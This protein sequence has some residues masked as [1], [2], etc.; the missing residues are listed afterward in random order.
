MALFYFNV[1]DGAVPS[2]D[3]VGVELADLAA[4]RK[5]AAVFAGEML[6]D[7]P[8]QF[9]DAQGWRLAVTDAMGRTLFTIEVGKEASGPLRLKLH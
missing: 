4:A 3:D 1:E 2:V 7:C 5:A 6:R 8:E 9:W